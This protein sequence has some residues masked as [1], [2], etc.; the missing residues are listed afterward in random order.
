MLFRSYKNK[1]FTADGLTKKQYIRRCQQYAGTQYQRHKEIL[2]PDNLRGKDWHIDHIYSVTD[3]F[4]NDVPINV[5]SD[6]TNLRLI[7]STENYKKTKNSHKSLAELYEDFK[8]H[9]RD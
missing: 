7:S 3:G 9:T 5:I 6:V 4:L 1:K 8:N 2:D